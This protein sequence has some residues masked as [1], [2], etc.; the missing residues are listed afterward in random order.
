[1]LS[2][3]RK[4][5]LVSKKQLI[6]VSKI[7]QGTDILSSKQLIPVSKSTNSGLKKNNLFLSQNAL[8]EQKAN[9]GLKKTTYSCLKNLS[10]N[11]HIELQSTY[12][13]LKKTRNCLPD[14]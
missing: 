4:L 2:G 9:S 13:C 5:I 3:N 6:P 1:M 12:S 7:S 8:R 10:G 14:P 11:R